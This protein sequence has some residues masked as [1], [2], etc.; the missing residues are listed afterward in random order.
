VTPD[1][2]PVRVASGTRWPMRAARPKRST[3]APAPLAA[4]EPAGLPSRQPELT[5]V[6]P[7]PGANKERIR[8]GTSHRDLPGAGH[9]RRPGRRDVV[10]SCGYQHPVELLPISRSERPAASLIAFLGGRRDCDREHGFRESDH[11]YGGPGRCGYALPQGGPGV[12]DL[13]E[14]GISWSRAEYEQHSTKSRRQVTNIFPS[15]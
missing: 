7:G 4:T 5:T 6:S 10:S 13:C 1:L 2:P 8:C 9:P 12:G 3:A 14:L 15:A 11:D